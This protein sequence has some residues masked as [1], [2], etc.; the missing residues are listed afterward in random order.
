MK[1]GKTARL[2]LVNFLVLAGLVVA[3][4]LIARSF[5]PE[6][7]ND[8]HSEE[9]SRGVKH[10]FTNLYSQ[11]VRIP[12]VGYDLTFSKQ[13]KLI[14]ILGDLVSRGYG[15]DFDDIY[16]AKF[17]RIMDAVCLFTPKV[18]AFS[19]L[20]NNLGDAANALEGFIEK[21]ETPS[22]CAVIYQF[23]YNDITPYNKTLL[24]AQTPSP[25]GG[26]AFAKWHYKWLN[27]MVSFRVAQYYSVWLLARIRTGCQKNQG[28]ALRQYSWAYCSKSIK[29]ESEKAWNQFEKDLERL[30]R[31]TSSL[32]SRLYVQIS[33]LL[34]HI[35]KDGKHPYY[36]I[37]VCT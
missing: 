37:G 12:Y 33:P 27:R 7:A 34:Y 9:L 32:N 17:Q 22:V 31:T 19:E 28:L 3:V 10:S 20:G 25:P 8:V 24:K 16:W 29:D 1:L 5:Y 4:E 36:N 23:N 30:Y 21:D 35:D 2:F 15:L 18:V 26:L 6:L 11:K 13:D 14:I